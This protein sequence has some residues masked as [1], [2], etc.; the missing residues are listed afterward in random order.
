L[1]LRNKAHDADASVANG[2]ATDRINAAITTGWNNR[3]IEAI[4]KA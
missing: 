2:I 4:F 1:S 3:N